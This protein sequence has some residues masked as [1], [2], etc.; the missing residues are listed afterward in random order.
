MNLNR[1]ALLEAKYGSL[2]KLAEDLINKSLPMVIVEDILKFIGEDGFIDE[3]AS[4]EENL[5]NILLEI[6]EPVDEMGA[7]RLGEEE[8]AV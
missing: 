7:V 3:E 6:L 1:V 2:Y 8:Y 4:P 5:K